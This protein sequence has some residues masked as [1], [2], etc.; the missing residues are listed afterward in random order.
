VFFLSLSLPISLSLSKRK[1]KKKN[2][3]IKR[4]KQN[5]IRENYKKK[6]K[7]QKLTATTRS[8]FCVGQLLLGVGPALEYSRDAQ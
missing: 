8:L 4:N 5:P 1:K 7:N 6:K 3:K 2:S